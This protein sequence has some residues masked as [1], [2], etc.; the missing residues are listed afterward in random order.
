MRFCGLI[1]QQVGCTTFRAKGN[2][3][4]RHLHL[5]NGT[6]LERETPS[7]SEAPEIL[8]FKVWVL[9]ISPMI[10]GSI[11]ICGAASER[12]SSEGGDQARSA[13]VQ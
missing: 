5:P 12:A 4:A 11:R 7:P 10:W 2:K 1:W 8:Q 3:A 9:D 13:A 6:H